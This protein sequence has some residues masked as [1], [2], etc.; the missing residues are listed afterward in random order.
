MFKRLLSY[1]LAL[2]VAA[3]SVFVPVTVSAEYTEVDEAVYDQ[4]PQEFT[5]LDISGVA[6]MAFAD[7]VAD[8]NVGGWSDQGEIN[9]MREFTLYGEQWFGG[10]KYNIIDPAKNDGKAIITL[11]GQGKEGIM[12]RAEIPVG[13]KGAGI[14]FLHAAA[15]VQT[16][17]ATYT[18]VY[19]DGSKYEQ[20]IRNNIENFNFWGANSSDVAWAAWT[21]A[22]KSTTACSIFMY[23]MENPNPDK[24]IEKIVCE[25][26]GDGAFDMI[27]AAT[28]TDSGPY[29]MI[30]T[31]RGN[32]DTSDWIR[33][34]GYVRGSLRGTALDMTQYVSADAPSGKRGW[35][36]ADGD[37]LVFDDGTLVRL[38]GADTSCTEMFRSHE[39][40][41]EKLEEI[42]SWG[43]NLLRL[44]KYGQTNHSQFNIYTSGS[45]KDHF[46]DQRVDQLCYMVAKMKELGMYLLLDLKV[47]GSSNEDMNIR[48][49]VAENSGWLGGEDTT[50]RD[51]NFVKELMLTYNP[52]TGM[53]LGE[54]PTICMVDFK[55]ENS[56]MNIT[57]DGV[58][59]IGDEIR[60]RF[61]NWLIEKYGTTEELR[62]AWTYTG[63]DLLK[64]G[65]NLE[66]KTVELQYSGERSN[67]TRPRSEDSTNFICDSM[68]EYARRINETL[69]ECGY[70]G[71]RTPTTIWGGEYAALMYV[72]TSGESDYVDTHDYWSH[73]SG[74]NSLHGNV[75]IGW[76]APISMLETNRFGY[77]GRIFNQNIYD[78]PHTITEW[79]ECDI[80]PTMSEGFPLMA[81]FSAYQNWV[82]MAF[83]AAMGATETMILDDTGS[84]QL[85]NNDFWAG[86]PSVPDGFWFYGGHPVKMAVGPASALLFLRGDVIPAQ[87]GFYHRNRV[88]DYF[89]ASNSDLPTNIEL[90]LSGKTGVSYDQR[91]YDPEYN[92]ND[93]LYRGYMAQKKGIPYV[94]DTGEIRTDMVNASLELNTEK[95]QAVI[96][97]LDGKR[98]ETDDMIVEVKD[99]PFAT[100]LLS[101]IDDKPIWEADRLLVTAVGDYRGTDEVR[102][103]DG[104]S[105]IKG[106]QFPVLIEQ[107]LGKLTIKTKDDVTVY[108]LDQAGRR[109]KTLTYSRDENGWVVI[110]MNI[111]NYCTNYEVVR[112]SAVEGAK[113]NE[114]I[115]Y[116]QIEVKDVFTDMDGYEWAKDKVERNFLWGTMSG[117][118]ET[119]FRPGNSITKGDFA[120][121]VY[122]A[123]KLSGTTSEMFE[124]VATDDPNFNAIRILKAS[125]V[126]NGDENGNF[127][128]N[129]TISRQDALT[130]FWRA[131]KVGGCAYTDKKGG[132]LTKFKDSGDIASYAKTSVENMMAQKY[133]SDLFGGISFNAEAPLT[134]VE[135]GC[136]AYGLLWE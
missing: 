26:P 76:N 58:R 8:D 95:T 14:Y 119:E 41:D 73:P 69:D 91:A 131:I 11:S 44:H 67:S 118:S 46:D 89:N 21:G 20:P 33:Y 104:M 102:S 19:E 98:F 122:K 51:I 125:G 10:V 31:D 52:Y 39:E 3:T 130:M 117:V 38:W 16:N 111:D 114:H 50:Q 81:I 127:N 93:I 40:I 121:V 79:D 83:T 5:P 62:K 7:D 59:G 77:M 25:T 49:D 133:V 109:T 29:K 124:D 65:E 64:E 92:D 136:L 90:G 24:V 74:D 42:A 68:I 60:V 43:F 88:N 35:M 27:V 129:A 87:S 106:G 47:T 72:L 97:R 12:N 75:Q 82:P 96:G 53:T 107:I 78:M 55:N 28:L 108:A 66:D 9:D 99:N 126:V 37:K 128:P 57:R 1:V 123:T 135:A 54:D 13:K 134:R 56:G 30:E 86:D 85:L 48:K 2:G 84:R 34:D 115:V 18:L 15:W 45:G 6:N 120:S 113:A 101:A 110:D 112:N 36:K 61:N 4:Y 70:K 63:K 103:R 105:V 94:S 22:N 132:E 100:M 17:I 116:D 80:N 71:L 32:P 23:V